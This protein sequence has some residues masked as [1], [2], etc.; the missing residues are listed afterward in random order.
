MKDCSFRRSQPASLALQRVLMAQM[1]PYPDA[2]LSGS[3]TRDL[4]LA[5]L[6]AHLRRVVEHL[7]DL[8]HRRD[9]R[10]QA[11]ALVEL[12]HGHRLLLEPA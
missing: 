2:C 6:V 3:A 10:A 12:L 11:L 1:C 5:C 4:A 8:R 9:D 7:L